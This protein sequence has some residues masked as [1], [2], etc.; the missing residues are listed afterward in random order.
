MS[1]AGPS[2]AQQPPK[3]KQ[4][5]LTE[6]QRL[7]E[8]AKRL[9]WVEPKDFDMS[10]V[11]KRDP[12][13]TREAAKVNFDGYL[14]SKKYLRGD[15]RAIA[16]DPTLY[17]LV[18]VKEDVC[19]IPVR[20]G[21]LGYP[22]QWFLH[23]DHFDPLKANIMNRNA[24]ALLLSGPN[25]PRVQAVIKADGYALVLAKD[26]FTAE[27]V[28]GL[29]PLLASDGMAVK[30]VTEP[31]IDEFNATRNERV[32]PNIL[33]K[34]RNHGWQRR[35]GGPGKRGGRGGQAQGQQRGQGQ[36]RNDR[37]YQT[38]G[39]QQIQEQQSYGEDFDPEFNE[40]YC[41]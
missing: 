10:T 36:R 39:P 17:C 33:I 20:L 26:E 29:I 38:N 25:G 11:Q 27:F 1:E 9:R 5:K 32:D 2:S 35:R 16:E 34:F 19:P 21:P 12:R 14:R 37:Q 22:R 8:E 13:P 40:D 7:K 15:V 28:R 41:F 30:E 23:N 4:K 24:Q 31:E 3:K 6:R 18:S